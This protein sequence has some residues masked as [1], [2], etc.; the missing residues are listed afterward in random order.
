MDNQRIGLTTKQA[1]ELLRRVGHN[2]LPVQA[3][4]R[5]L[6]ILLSQFKS[7][8]I[9]ILL[10][11]SV[12]SL[13]YG[14]HLDFFLIIAVIFLNVAMGFGQEYG[15]HRTSE[16]L[17]LLVSPTALVIRNGKRVQIERIHIVPGDLVVLGPGDK[18]PADGKL[19]ESSDLLVR[20]SILTGES[21]AVLKDFHASALLFM[22]TDVLSGEG[23]MEVTATGKKTELGKIGSTLTLAE[24]P[25]TP[26]RIS[27]EELSKKL[28]IIIVGICF[29]IFVIGV[30]LG[31]NVSDML[32]LSVILSVAGIPEGLPI[33]ITIILS[34]AAKN[35]LKR[36]GLVKKLISVETLGST[37]VLCLDKTGTLTEGNMKV[38]RF[39]YT[40]PERVVAATLLANEQR[41]DM[42][43]SLWNYLR[44][45]HHDLFSSLPQGAV[46]IKKIP[47][48]SERKYSV[49]VGTMR[50]KTR[51]YIVGAP[52]IVIKFCSIPDERKQE[53]DE[54]IR[55]WTS[56]GYRLLSFASRDGQH[57]TEHPSGFEWDGLVAIEDPLRA[58]VR[59]TIEKATRAGLSVKIITGDH[60]DTA[61]KVLDNL[62][63]NLSED[64]ILTG[65]QID[66]MTRTEILDRL[67]KTVL[68]A[69][70]TPHHKLL[71][72]ELL[73]EQGH[74]VAMTGD[75]VNDAQALKRADIGI[76]MGNSSDLAKDS[77]DLILLNNDFR[78]IIKSIEKGR[79][80]YSNLKKSVAYVLSNSFV[81]IILIVLALL[82]G[83]PTP[84]SVAQILWLHLI[85]DG[86]P[87]IM[88]GFEPK[89]DDLMKTPITK[90][91]VKARSLLDNMG[92]LTIAGISGIVGCASLLVFAFAYKSTND[93]GF[94]R[95]VTFI[96]VGMVDLIYVFSFKSLRNPVLKLKTLLNN[97]VMLLSILY[98][99]I[100]LFGALYIHPLSETLQLKSVSSVYLLVG[101]G[102]GLL[103]VLWM[104]FLKYL[105]RKRNTL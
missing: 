101:L 62:G 92:L 40:V 53:L 26:L 15:A 105:S 93:L 98:G 19:I 78:V 30:A 8:L 16:S 80:I 6:S 95:T 24:E 94:A 99:F 91:Q 79:L 44:K 90:E 64:T 50:G 18:I 85:C 67:D 61:Q 63:L 43:V 10:I 7:P 23:I 32:R 75:G 36:N 2:T 34:V 39:D 28:G 31:K 13:F 33:T 77:G 57:T 87:D 74:V 14:E 47:F 88:L 29:A 27:L 51:T 97:K 22:G 82:A 17:K 54:Q 20:E 69:R 41:T 46:R 3:S 37:T 76:V 71:L 56:H 11:V 5:W 65:S 104:E 1:E 48:S 25:P 58:E 66:R 103:S 52:D 55:K 12:I 96:G 83:L 21:E 68:F 9:Y 4:N 38:T 84:L 89:E 81:E 86:P 72:V 35:I 59:E 45:N 60:R 100:L 49:T 73:Q 102:L 42:E 70:V